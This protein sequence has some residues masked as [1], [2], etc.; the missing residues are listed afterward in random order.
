[1]F[2]W[3]MYNALITRL[4]LPVRGGAACMQNF[5]IGCLRQLH[6]YVQIDWRNVPC[7]KSTVRLFPMQISDLSKNYVNKT[8][9]KKTGGFTSV[10]TQYFRFGFQQSALNG[11]FCG[12]R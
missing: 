7:Y 11:D 9:V 3:L 12:F 1:M 5:L 8:V 4:L 10:K 6:L 2:R